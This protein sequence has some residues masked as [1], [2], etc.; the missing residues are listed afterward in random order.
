VAE[1]AASLSAGQ[2]Q[3]ISIARALLPNPSLFIFDEATS[4]IDSQTEF[5]VQ[6]ALENLWG[7][8]EFKK[9]T[10]LI[11]A[12]R[13]STIQRCDRIFAFKD[14]CI[15]ESG[16]FK[17]LMDLKGYTYSLQQKQYRLST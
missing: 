3:L 13:L 4:H 6:E 5:L 16:S 8:S 9:T 14:G 17:E 2:K 1:R 12:H 7:M 11:I 15:V 10:G